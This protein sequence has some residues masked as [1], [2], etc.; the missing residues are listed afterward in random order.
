PCSGPRWTSLGTNVPGGSVTSRTG[1][2]PSA[3]SS[4]GSAQTSG[5]QYWRGAARPAAGRPTPRHPPTPPPPPPPAPPPPP[6]PPPPAAAGPS[7]PPPGRVA[8]G[9]ARI[10]A[11]GLSPP[12]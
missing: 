3:T 11:R 9:T 6:P 5:R 4:T 7:A 12:P 1:C 10:P 2:R 8:S